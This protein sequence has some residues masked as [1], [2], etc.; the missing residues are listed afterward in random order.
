[1]SELSE[2]PDEAFAAASNAKAD[3]DASSQITINNNNLNSDNADGRIS[4]DFYTS[5]DDA[6]AD[7]DDK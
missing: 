7:L 4:K 5:H 3:V 2:T 6:I 1:L